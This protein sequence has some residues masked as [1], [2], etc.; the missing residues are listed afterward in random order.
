M[1]H[2]PVVTWI[3]LILAIVTLIYAIYIA[4]DTRVI[5]DDIEKT[6]HMNNSNN[7]NEV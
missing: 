5:L 2:I 6:I 4:K 7:S 1:E 3:L